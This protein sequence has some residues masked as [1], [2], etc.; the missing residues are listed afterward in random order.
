MSLNKKVRS[1]GFV[2]LGYF[3][4]VTGCNFYTHHNV[5]YET[6]NEKIV[7]KADGIFAYTTLGINESDGAINISRDSFLNWR[8]YKDKDG[9][10]DVD[11]VYRKL[12]NPLV[13]GSHSRTFDRDKDL[14]QFPKVF[15][16]ADRDFK[17]QMQRFKPYINR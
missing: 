11:R 12:G 6:D 8:S 3:G 7:K 14:T 16:E 5:S 13:R 10:G 17:N 1:V 2:L 9:D 15:E 4:F